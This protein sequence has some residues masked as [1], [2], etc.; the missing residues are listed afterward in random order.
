MCGTKTK[1][2]ENSSALEQYLTDVTHSKVIAVDI[3]KNE[4]WSAIKN[5]D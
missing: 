3:N 2:E 1:S 5:V 4:I